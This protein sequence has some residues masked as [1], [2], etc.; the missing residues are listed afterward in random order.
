MWRKPT[1]V[2]GFP[3]DFNKKLLYNYTRENEK[4]RGDRKNDNRL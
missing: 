2:N 4:K 1:C 3:F